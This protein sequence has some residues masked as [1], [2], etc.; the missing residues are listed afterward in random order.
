MDD[1]INRRNIIKA[2]LTQHKEDKNTEEKRVQDKIKLDIMNK[3]TTFLSDIRFDDVQTITKYKE[4]LYLV[5]NNI[6]NNIDNRQITY[7]IEYNNGLTT[8]K[9]EIAKKVFEILYTKLHFCIFTEDEH[10]IIHFVKNS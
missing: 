2:F 10:E 8:E 5:Y 4:S 1:K 7:T 9:R 3:Q 6:D